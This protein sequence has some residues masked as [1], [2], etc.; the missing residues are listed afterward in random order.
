M[1]L[2]AQ[3]IDPPRSQCLVPADGSGLL[4]SFM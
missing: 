1:N 4:D 2:K 3:G